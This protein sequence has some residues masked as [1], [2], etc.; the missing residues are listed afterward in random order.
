MAKPTPLQFR[1]ILMAVLMAAAL[2]WN[3]SRDGQ[4]WL[5]AIFGV[6]CVLAIASAFL[7]KREA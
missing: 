4:W 1:N 2:V 5:S 6:G 3:V 7:N